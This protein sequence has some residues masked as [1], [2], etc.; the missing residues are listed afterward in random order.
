M[1][2]I[3][4]LVIGLSVSMSV[5]AVNSQTALSTF[6]QDLKNVRVKLQAGKMNAVQAQI[7]LQA[8]QVRQNNVLIAQNAEIL[9]GLQHESK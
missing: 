1:K 8:I 4:A 2:K 3:V 6:Q 5:F 9:K 7:L